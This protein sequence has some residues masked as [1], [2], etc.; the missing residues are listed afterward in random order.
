M[1]Y[2]PSDSHG[3]A[4]SLIFHY[5]ASQGYILAAR[6]SILYLGVVWG[7]VSPISFHFTLS[8]ILFIPRPDGAFYLSGFTSE[9]ISTNNEYSTFT[10]Q[11][12]LFLLEGGARQELAQ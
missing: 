3:L 7:E 6:F 5:L 1:Q 9:A 10:F 2:P 12:Y 4:A 8:Q 11:V